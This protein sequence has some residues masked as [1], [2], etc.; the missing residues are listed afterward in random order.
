[1]KMLFSALPGLL[2]TVSGYSIAEY[3]S[4]PPVQH[5]RNV[6]LLPSVDEWS[7][8]D[9]SPVSASSDKS[10]ELGVPYYNDQSL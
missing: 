10:D 6:M 7:P 2:L 1:M 9:L 8:N 5:S 4:L 3:S